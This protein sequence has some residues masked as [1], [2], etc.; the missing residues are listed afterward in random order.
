MVD[1]EGWATTTDP[2]YYDLYPGDGS[3]FRFNGFPES[4]EYGQLCKYRSPSGH[5]EEL[6]GTDIEIIRDDDGHLRQ[7]LVPRYLCDVV[8]DSDEA[9]HIDMHPREYV[10]G[11]KDANGL[12]VVTTDAPVETWS[13]D[14]PTPGSILNLR[15][16]QRTGTKTN[17]Y[18]YTYDA[19]VEDWR[20]SEGDVGQHGWVPPGCTEAD[21]HADSR[22]APHLEGEVADECSDEGAPDETRWV[23]G[24]G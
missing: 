24:A 15:V 17:A 1:A 19:D 23:G 2:A 20:L 5:E 14:N 9:Y 13:F 6:S 10:S 4:E 18:L 16:R 7:V 11:N 8:V 12:Y 21:L 3:M 22:C